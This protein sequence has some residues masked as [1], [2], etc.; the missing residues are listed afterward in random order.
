MNEQTKD[1][2]RTA[3]REQYG[4]IARSTIGATCC[5]PGSCGPLKT[6]HQFSGGGCAFEL[7][8]TSMPNFVT[9]RCS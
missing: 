3:V 5:A 1:E 6:S 4:S 7:P 9:R 2:V 8:G